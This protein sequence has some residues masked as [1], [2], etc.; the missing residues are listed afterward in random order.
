M[1][2]LI[3]VPQQEPETIESR[4][5]FRE[6]RRA[7]IGGSDVAAILGYA[8][9][10]DIA[11]VYADKLGLSEDKDSEVM[12]WGRALETKVAEVYAEKNGVCLVKPGQVI[13]PT[14]P[15]LIA[16]PDFFVYTEEG[17]S[18]IGGLEIKTAGQYRAA[19]WG[20]DGTDQI[21]EAY[22]L[23]VQ[24]YMEV[25]NL[26]WYDVAVL[27]GG[28]KYRQYRI[29]R[30]REMYANIIPHLTIFWECVQSQTLPD[31]SRSA[32]ARSLLSRFFKETDSPA[33]LTDHLFE[34]CAQLR[35][36]ASARIESEKE[37]Q[38]VKNLIAIEM[39]ENNVLYGPDFKITYKASAPRKIVDIKGLTAELEIAPEVLERHT[40]LSQSERSVRLW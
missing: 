1:N 20:E 4:A 28:N 18:P 2:Q 32:H 17:G 22:I 9:G 14:I 30:D 8:K 10:R 34:L 39:G 5:A 12:F 26:D 24:H 37:E 38:R 16:N 36:V 23:Q 19:D 25:T 35:M 40:K 31:I 13:H 27:I 3:R 6:Q 21:P 33:P 7:G 11:S 29:H 15:Y